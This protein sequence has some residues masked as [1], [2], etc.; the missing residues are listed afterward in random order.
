MD[1]PLHEISLDT[2]CA[3]LC[4]L[5]GIEPPKYAASPN[6]ALVSAAWESQSA[7]GGAKAETLLSEAPPADRAALAWKL[8]YA[9]DLTGGPKVSGAQ[10]KEIAA[11]K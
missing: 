5:T 10:K 4:A 1:T 9:T 3:S 8:L 2:L 11:G 6:E 7:G